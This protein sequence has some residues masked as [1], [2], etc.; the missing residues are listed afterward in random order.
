MKRFILFV[1]IGG[2]STLLQFAFLIFFIE[3]KLLNAVAASAAGYVLSAFF[4]Y[5]ANYHYTF[6]SQQSH[7][8]AFPK[9][10]IAVALGLSIN[11]LLFALFL[12]LLGQYWPFAWPAPYLVAQVLATGITVVVNFLVHKFWIYREQ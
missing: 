11:T 2:L 6:K 10:A 8:Q 9:F 7:W 3:T 5:W 4:N 1:G 12:Y